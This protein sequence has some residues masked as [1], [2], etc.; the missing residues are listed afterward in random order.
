MLISVKKGATKEYLPYPGN[1]YGVNEISTWSSTKY[2][3]VH[4]C[5]KKYHICS[6]I[7]PRILHVHINGC[8]FRRYLQGLTY[9]ALCVKFPN[10]TPIGTLIAL[11]TA[12]SNLGTERVSTPSVTPKVMY[13]IGVTDTL[14]AAQMEIM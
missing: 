5:D 3:L 9:I 1:R 7:I 6:K 8:I 10:G 12:S 4:T 11:E 2:P 13:G 14:V